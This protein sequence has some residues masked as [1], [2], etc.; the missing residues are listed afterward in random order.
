MT[1]ESSDVP[2]ELIGEVARLL[3]SIFLTSPSRLCLLQV[4]RSPGAP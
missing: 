3:F 4:P 2:R 1:E